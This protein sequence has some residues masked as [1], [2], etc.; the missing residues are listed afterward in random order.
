MFAHFHNEMLKK[1]MKHRKLQEMFQKKLKFTVLIR[2]HRDVWAEENNFLVV[3]F[4]LFIFDSSHPYV[5]QVSLELALYPEGS[6][7]LSSVDNSG[8]CRYIW[9][10]VL[11]ITVAPLILR[12]HVQSPSAD[13]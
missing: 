11:D 9:P 2:Q 7:C 8:L 4:V 12:G 10:L 5:A 1:K 13:A 3:C 6:A